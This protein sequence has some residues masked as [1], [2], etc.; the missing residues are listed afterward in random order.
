MS[1]TLTVLENT[2]RYAALST[3]TITGSIK[4]S[5]TKRVKRPVGSDV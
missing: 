4:A 3:L 1:I 2:R 5:L